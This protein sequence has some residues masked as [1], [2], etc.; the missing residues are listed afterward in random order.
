[1]YLNHTFFPSKYYQ[2]EES[3]FA[4][5]ADLFCNRSEDFYED[6]PIPKESKTNFEINFGLGIE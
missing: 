4:I 1:M 6:Y 3:E 2:I 5:T